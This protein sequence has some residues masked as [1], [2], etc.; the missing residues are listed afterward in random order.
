MKRKVLTYVL[1]VFIV[2]MLGFI[3]GMMTRTGTQIYADTIN[4]PPFSPPGILFPIAWTVLYALMGIGFARVLLAD[5]SKIRNM[6]IG[7][8][9]CQLIL[10][11][12]WCFIFFNAQNFVLA[13][14]ELIVMFIAVLIMIVFF[15]KTDAFA[16][17]LQIP[18][19]L[20]LCFATYLNIGVIIL[21]V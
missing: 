10:N 15:G 11:L 19:V 4:K 13:L 14:V 17:K 16:A 6:S 18:Y 5:S 3:A 1:S 12:A 21:N 7:F 8:F 20:W 9:G 2:E